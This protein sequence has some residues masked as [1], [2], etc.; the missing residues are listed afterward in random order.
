MTQAGFAGNLRY[1][2]LPAALV[3]VLAGAGWVEVVRASRRWAPLV[4]VLLAV[5]AWPFVAAD[6]QK[7]REDRQQTLTESNFYGPNLKAVIAKAGGE[8]KIKSC[9]T[10]FSGPFQV[11]SVA[12]RLHLHLNE[13]VIFPFGPGTALSMGA[14]HLSVDPRYPEF[15]KTRHWIVG[16]TCGRL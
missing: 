4:A 13:V 9:G 5:A 11:P 6:V 7:L 14:T 12:W 15:T 1:V 10:V 16:S 8:A 3:C 2:A